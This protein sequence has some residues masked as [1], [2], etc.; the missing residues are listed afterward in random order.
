MSAIVYRPHAGFLF[1]VGTL[2]D[3]YGFLCS[4]VAKH[5]NLLKSLPSAKMKDSAVK[6]STY[7]FFKLVF[8]DKLVAYCCSCFCPNRELR[9]I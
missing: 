7:L 1:G 4:V 5:A 3:L 8:A 2:L 6:Y 9:P